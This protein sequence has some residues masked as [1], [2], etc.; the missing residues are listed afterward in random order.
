MAERLVGDH[1]ELRALRPEDAERTLAWRQS[2]RARWL[3]AGAQTVGEQR[4]WI[5]SR[6][7][8]ERNYIIELKDGRAV[9]MLSLIGIDPVHRHAETARFLIGDEDAVRGVPAAV[10]SMKLLY[11]H[12]FGELG[13]NRLYGLVPEGNR[14][15]I[16]WQCYLGMREEGRLR[17][18][19]FFDGVWQDAVCL[20]MLEDEYREIAAPRMTTLIAA[21]RSTTKETIS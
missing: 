3:N 9:G 6:P 2:P 21:A 5:A 13:L 19:L 20:G 4:A 16:T 10:E 17:R 18:H 1:I 8:S 7:D 12:A 14:R 15:S 11:D